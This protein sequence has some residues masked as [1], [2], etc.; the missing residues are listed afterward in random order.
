MMKRFSLLSNDTFKKRRKNTAHSG[1]V[2][3]APQN[4]TTKFCISRPRHT[5]DVQT[6][7]INELV[8]I[9]PLRCETTFVHRHGANDRGHACPTLGGHAR[10]LCHRNANNL[11]GWLNEQ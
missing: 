10:N 2:T 1:D 6:R 4:Q 3:N 5:D 9:R 11:T 8:T 7:N